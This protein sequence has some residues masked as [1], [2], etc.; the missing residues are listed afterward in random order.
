MTKQQV[1]L[2]AT[3]WAET[4]TGYDLEGRPVSIEDPAGHHY[5]WAKGRYCSEDW[6]C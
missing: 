3:T 6:R 1:K 4:V 2:D 5:P